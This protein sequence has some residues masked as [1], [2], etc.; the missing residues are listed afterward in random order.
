MKKS[1]IP[2]VAKTQLPVPSIAQFEKTNANKSPI[3]GKSF[4][5]K[6]SAPRK[7]GGRTPSRS[8]V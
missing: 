4:I 1:K 2:A 7:R 6:V 3:G 5:P 8:G